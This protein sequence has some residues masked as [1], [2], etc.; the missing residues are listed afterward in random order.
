VAFFQ[1][2]G[3]VPLFIVISSSRAR[4][5]IMASPSSFIISLEIQSDPTDLFFQLAAIL[6]LM[7]LLSMVNGLLEISPCIFGILPS[8]LNTDE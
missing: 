3:R 2:P 5:G 7:I 6:L 8:L 4:Y 1:S